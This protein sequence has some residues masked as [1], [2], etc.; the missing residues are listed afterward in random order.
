MLKWP[1]YVPVGRD[2]MTRTQVSIFVNCMHQI[3]TKLY[4]SGYNQTPA[5]HNLP[6]KSMVRSLLLETGICWTSRCSGIRGPKEKKRVWSQKK[7]GGKGVSWANG[8]RTSTLIISRNLLPHPQDT[9]GRFP[10]DER[11]VDGGTS[12]NLWVCSQIRTRLVIDKQRKLNS[13]FQIILIWNA[14]GGQVIQATFSCNLSRNIVA[15]QVAKLCCPYYHP[16][17]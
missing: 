2:K 7:K 1:G 10:G 4:C 11:P 8:H 12:C 3:E 5:L 13:V 17:K 14:Y 6:H 9:A 16:R 15:V